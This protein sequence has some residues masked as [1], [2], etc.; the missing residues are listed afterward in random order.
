MILRVVSENTFRWGECLH[1]SHQPETPWSCYSM[2]Y[3]S[4]NNLCK[5]YTKK[6]V[7]IQLLWAS[8]MFP[9]LWNK[10]R[11]TYCRTCPERSDLSWRLRP[12]FMPLQFCSPG[13]QSHWLS[14]CS[15]TY[16]EFSLS[17]NF[18][19]TIPPALRTIPMDIYMAHGYA[20]IYFLPRYCSHAMNAGLECKPYH[21]VQQINAPGSNTQISG[22]VYKSISPTF[23]RNWGDIY[24][25]LR[26][27]QEGQDSIAH[28]GILKNTFWILLTTSC[29]QYA[30]CIQILL[31]RFSLRRIQTEAS[32]P[33][34]AIFK[35]H[36]L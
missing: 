5:Q 22:H 33:P 32:F 12:H 6:S 3:H 25:F 15:L 9:L 27:S 19:H 13:L 14:C 2:D 18:A 21:E 1:T 16:S 8:G 20:S 23:R 24:R 11:R 17:R 30:L 31:S 7:M 29:W 35:S 26:K 28:S 4:I 36:S 10:S 34:S